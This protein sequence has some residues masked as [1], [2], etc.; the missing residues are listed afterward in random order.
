M[1][2]YEKNIA[3]LSS[4]RPFIYDKLKNYKK[5]EDIIY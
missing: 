1:T 5:I 2:N 4:V 3:A